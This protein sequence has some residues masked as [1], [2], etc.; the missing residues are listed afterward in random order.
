MPDHKEEHKTT[1]IVVPAALM[2]QWK[3][4]I[5]T[6]TNGLFTVHIHHGKDKLKKE[7]QVKRKDVI[8]TSYQTLCTDF[9]IAGHVEPE[10][11]AE[12]VATNGGVLARTTFYRVIADE[13]QFIRNRR[14]RASLSMAMVRAKYRWMLTGTPVTNTLAD[15][16]GLLRFGHF[17][18]WNDWDSFNEWIAKVQLFDAPLAG[19][20]SQVILKPLLLRRTK[21]SDL[22]GKPILQL[23]PKEIELVRLEFSREE[24]DLYNSFEQ[25]TKVKLNKFIRERTLLKNHAAVLVMILRLRQLCCH[26]H[27]I[28][29]QTAGFEDPTL[30]MG[31]DFEKDLSR[32]RKAMGHPWVNTIRQEFL[33]RAAATELL[34]FSDEDDAS[35]P[36]CPQCSETF[37]KETAYVLVCGHELCYEC[38]LNT[39]NAPIAHN[40]IFGYGN[41]KENLA[42]EKA[43]EEAEAKG[44]RPCPTCQKMT[45]MGDP[46]I[47]KSAAFEPTDE[48]LTNYARSKR[49][50]K[51]SSRKWKRSYSPVK[52][53]PPSPASSIIELSDSDEELPDIMDVFKKKPAPS[54]DKK[55]KK[56]MV[57]SSSDEEK[58]V[59]PKSSKSRNKGKAAVKKDD[60]SDIE[61]LGKSPS[62]RKATKRQG[63]G[64]DNSDSDVEFVGMSPSKRKVSG[65]KRKAKDDGSD[66]EVSAV[67]PARRRKKAR[68]SFG[69]DAESSDEDKENS[70]KGLSDSVI[71][72]WSRGD[73]DMEPS[74]KM[75]ALVSFL[76]KW[77]AS[78]DKVICYSQW[79]SMLDL[80]EILLSRHGVRS[81]RFDGKMDRVSRDQTLA[82]F[83]QP[84]SPRIILISTRCGSVGLNLTVANRVV[85]MDLSWNYAAESQAYDRCHRIGQDKPVFVKRLVVQNTIEERMLRLQD[86]KVGLAEAALGEGTGAKLH[87][88]SV[89]DIKYLFGMTPAR[90]DPPAQRNGPNRDT[91]ELSDA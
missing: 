37:S 29:S 63:G 84:G 61:F 48:E 64:L 72:T 38:I 56:K 2:Q 28:L 41:E 44:L 91:P 14:T 67:T 11:E 81:L 80:L 77:D 50:Q 22:E 16:Y 43:F 83:K 58:P 70:V 62:K 45:D 60:S 68:D 34:D 74:A 40:G 10:D 31:T 36:C 78:G 90:V 6:K 46:K 8:I 73:D 17:E 85:N 32:A 53:E 4:E 25:R 19:S 39:R 76:K 47:F 55:G 24:R 57:V 66:V 82:T 87:K 23:P 35:A 9:W 71:A 69:S 12:W 79:T 1:L 52:A 88:L 33:V 49:K 15:L 18:P 89:K 30:L 26:P 20:R 42:A 3:D 54:K 27:L 59:F 86:V 65:S 5:E 75:K 7:S 51:Q 21:D 13:A